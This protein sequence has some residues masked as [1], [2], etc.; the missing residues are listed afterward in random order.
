MYFEKR[1]FLILKKQIDINNVNIENVLV[2]Y[3]YCIGEGCWKYFVDYV[4]HFNNETKP[5]L[6]KLSKLSGSGKSF[7][8][9][10]LYYIC[11]EKNKD[12]LNEC[13]EIWNSIKDL[14]GKYFD[15][16]VSHYNKYKS[17]KIKPFEDMKLK[18]LSIMKDYQQ[19]NLHEQLTQLYLLIQFIEEIKASVTPQVVLGECKYMVKNETTKRYI[20]ENLFDSDACFNC[21]SI[22][23]F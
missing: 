2:S 21:N 10:K 20:T 6:I 1:S 12:I 19:K 23:S 22:F 17:A 18:L 7:E 3:K 5:I 16:E 14:I 13:A 4:N 9:V 11:C 8:K 15:V